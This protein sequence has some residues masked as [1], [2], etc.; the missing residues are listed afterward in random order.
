MPKFSLNGLQ[1]EESD[2]YIYLGVMF[3]DRNGCFHSHIEMKHD[4]ALRAIF[5]T[6]NQARHAAGPFI[7]HVVIN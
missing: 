4:N 3:T 7:I 2:Y 5:S 1:I 6:W